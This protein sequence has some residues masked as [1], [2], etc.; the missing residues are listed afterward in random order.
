M[1]RDERRQIMLLLRSCREAWTPL[2][3][4]YRQLGGYDKPLG[5]SSQD[6]CVPTS[7]A[8]AKVLNA[9][10][11]QPCSWHVRSGSYIINR[12]ERKPHSWVVGCYCDEAGETTDWLAD[13]T[14]DQFGAHRKHI[15][16]RW[17][18]VRKHYDAHISADQMTKA[19][20]IVR[21]HVDLWAGIFLCGAPDHAT[22]E[23]Q[24]QSSRTGY[25]TTRQRQGRQRP[26]AV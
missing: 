13:I 11:P 17:C 6:C 4:G 12:F 18:N 22:E 2:W 26:M 1:T 19:H 9:L 24:L 15:L 10:G 25:Q 20:S 21:T 3:D 8:L 16:S 5:S 14:A 23:R 7:F